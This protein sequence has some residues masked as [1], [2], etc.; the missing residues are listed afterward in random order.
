MRE[1]NDCFTISSLSNTRPWE[2]FYYTVQ[3]SHIIK[4]ILITDKYPFILAQQKQAFKNPQFL[5]GI[6]KTYVLWGFTLKKA[7]LLIKC[8]ESTT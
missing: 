6:Y 4:S 2:Y 5:N 3:T 8:T 7:G 1:F